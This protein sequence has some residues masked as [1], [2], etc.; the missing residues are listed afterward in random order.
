M[1]NCKWRKLSI[2]S[3]LQ[4]RVIFDLKR[5][6][7]SYTPHDVYHMYLSFGRYAFL[8]TVVLCLQQ[9]FLTLYNTQ[10]NYANMI[11]HWQQT[12]CKLYTLTR[13]LIN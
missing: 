7:L 9:L 12:F 10:H 11:A 5:Y 6:R 4:K 13:N 3:G 1:Y 8:K 2:Q